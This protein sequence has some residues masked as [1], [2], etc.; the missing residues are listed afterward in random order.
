VAQAPIVVAPTITKLPPGGLGAVL[1]A[2]SHGGVY[3]GQLVVAA[4]VRDGRASW[5]RIAACPIWP[6]H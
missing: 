4:G 5:F 2:G 1:A 3:P 6:R